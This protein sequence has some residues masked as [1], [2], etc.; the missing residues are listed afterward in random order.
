MKKSIHSVEQ[1]RLQAL[2]RQI[3]KEAGLR[4]SELAGRLGKPQSFV[5]K[6]ESGERRLDLIELNGICE[7]VG[8]SLVDFV[9]RFESDSGKLLL[10]R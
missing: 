5:S 4:Q 6:Y 3:R 9:K 1:E 10:K 8:V 7:G 2:L